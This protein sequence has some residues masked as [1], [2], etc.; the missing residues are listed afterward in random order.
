[1]SRTELA[2]AAVASTA[3]A[4]AL[5]GTAAAAPL[6]LAPDDPL[7]PPDACDPP[8]AVG[9]GGEVVAP[10]G[11]DE[12]RVFFVDF[13]VWGSAPAGDFGVDLSREL[14]AWAN[15]DPYGL[16]RAFECDPDCHRAADEGLVARV[17]PVFAQ[18]GG[19][20][21]EQRA[22]GHLRHWRVSFV[23]RRSGAAIALDPA[24]HCAAVDTLR[25]TALILAERQ[26][27]DGDTR[28]GLRVGREACAVAPMGRGEMALGGHGGVGGL[29]DGRPG[30]T[31]ALVDSG[32]DPRLAGA[33]HVSG[34]VQAVRSPSVHDRGATHLH[35]TAM[36]ELIRRLAP[37]DVAELVSH[38]VMTHEGT[39]VV[40]DAA[41][42][43]D[44]AV[45][46]GVGPTVVNLSL[47]WLP[48]QARSR[49]LVGPGCLTV[50][51]DIGETMRYA[52]AMAAAVD[53]PQRPVS[54]V[55]AAG[56]R[57]LSGED[58]DAFDVV[59]GGLFDPMTDGWWSHDREPMLMP[60]EYGRV[61][62]LGL[63]VGAVDARDNR[64]AL[65]VLPAEA[66]PR[67]VALG[68]HVASSSVEMLTAGDAT[69]LSGSS[70][71]A[72]QVSGA[73]ALAMDA[74]ADRAAQ[75]GD[76]QPVAGSTLEDLVYLAGVPVRRSTPDGTP[77][78]RLDESRLR[79]VLSCELLP[80]IIACIGDLVDEPQALAGECGEMVRACAAEEHDPEVGRPAERPLACRLEPA[81]AVVAADR[82]AA[83]WNDQQGDLLVFG[84]PMP[85]FDRTRADRAL[86]G[87]VGPQPRVPTCSDCSGFVDYRAGHVELLVFMS[88]QF[89]SDTR[90][91]DPHVMV[92]DQWGNKGWIAVDLAGAV[93]QPG[94][95]VQLRTIGG[96]PVPGK[97]VSASLV[98]T[99]EQWGKVSGYDASALKLQ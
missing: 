72:A 67:L 2:L 9:N 66:E 90:F 97:V 35:G 48:E 73:L 4:F 79:A 27:V 76:V 7:P 18:R 24:Q 51:D 68:D 88:K 84:D 78:H 60:A 81:S 11:C 70:L 8:A 22:D 28:A 53:R 55:V 10:Y 99:I 54:V 31:V 49:R 77:I 40:A 43:V 59:G 29:S 75:W 69:T 86:L 58:P 80:Q 38:R 94:S 15:R 36:A 45:F 34:E 52:M 87:G 56:N 17:E 14:S 25:R 63:A 30:A 26:G 83:R 85:N 5:A 46:D 16:C 91:R 65:S 82:D 96:L 13:P 6:C 89:P 92:H 71:A 44:A 33:L 61:S 41:R 23:G 95:A 74:V 62:G 50:E 93:L 12:A 32:V 42:A 37:A 1:M 19:Q 21:L 64:G 98:V 20:Q 47:G 3:A 39:G 57:P